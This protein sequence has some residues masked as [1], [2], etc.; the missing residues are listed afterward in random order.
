MK[1]VEDGIVVKSSKARGYGYYV[2]LYHQNGLFSLYSHTLKKGMASLGHHV[3]RGDV[4]A[5][6]GRSGNAR[7]Y[8]L[9]FE[10]IDLREEWNFD[11]GIDQFVQLIADGQK[12]SGQ[13]CERFNQLLFAKH[14]KVDPLANLPGLAFAKRQ[15][16][17]WTADQEII[18]TK[19]TA[20]QAQ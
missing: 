19:T 2:V 17:K 7:G 12:L 3:D 18:P 10:L 9:H 14:S 6:M 11:T 16:G 13:M 20:V 5:Y 4:I 15:N 8:H 1:A